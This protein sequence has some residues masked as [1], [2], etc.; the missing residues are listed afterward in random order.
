MS[1]RKHPPHA[2]LER[3]SRGAAIAARFAQVTVQFEHVPRT[4]AKVQRV[5]V[6]RDQR[7]VADPRFEFG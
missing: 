1:G 2:G 4:G 3:T 7:E 5:D 6:L